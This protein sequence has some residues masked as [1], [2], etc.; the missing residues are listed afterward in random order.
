[1]QQ[2]LAAHVYTSR[3]RETKWRTL[4]LETFKKLCV[5]IDWRLAWLVLSPNFEGSLNVID[6]W[7]GSLTITTM[8][9]VVSS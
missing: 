6:I 4:P 7:L 5:R 3:G 9:A 1:M 8:A 2:I